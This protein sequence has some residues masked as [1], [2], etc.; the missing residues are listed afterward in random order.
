MRFGMN[1]R[2]TMKQLWVAGLIC[3]FVINSALAAFSQHRQTLSTALSHKDA[4]QWREDLRFLA[5]ELPKRH[6]NLFH[7]MTR[8]QFERAV[9]R[10]DERIPS[11]SEQQIFVEMTRIVAQVEDGHTRVTKDAQGGFVIR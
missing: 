6:K 4:K 8:E 3:F 7:T 10:L 11:L 2:K 9:K 5:E 1:R